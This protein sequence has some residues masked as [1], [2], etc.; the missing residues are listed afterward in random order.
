[1]TSAAC[2]RIGPDGHRVEQ[3]VGAHEEGHGVAGGRAVEHDEL[4]RV[5]SPGRGRPLQL[6]D[7]AEHEDVL[8]T[9]SGGG[10]HVECA[11]GDEPAGYPAHPVVLQVL[12]QGVVGGHGAGPDVGSP[13]GPAAAR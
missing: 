8:D 10:D 13:V 5:G 1:M 9:R 6:L 11:R 3:A 7:L 2:A 12:E 4:G